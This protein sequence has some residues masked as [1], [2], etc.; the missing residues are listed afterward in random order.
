[1]KKK[2]PTIAEVKKFYDDQHTQHQ[3]KW[4]TKPNPRITALRDWAT[5]QVMRHKP[6]SM[7]D[8]GCGVGIL[9]HEMVSMVRH[10]VAID[11]SDNNIEAAKKHNSH[12]HIKYLCG[13]FT[14]MRL[15]VV[16]S[17]VCAFDVVEHIRP[18][19]RE[20]FLLN[21]CRHCFGTV[22]V[23]IPNPELLV[24]L[25]KTNPDILQIVDEPVYDKDF[26]MFSIEKKLSAG[27][28]IYYILKP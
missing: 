10:I 5:T 7:L 3:Q 19:D 24:T 20:E 21:V 2:E 11:L 27:K 26:S 13:D 9:T 22:L 25:K 6:K 12:K 16:F 23:S 14:Q 18:S 15:P 4:L 28:Y 8:I 17:L 1:M